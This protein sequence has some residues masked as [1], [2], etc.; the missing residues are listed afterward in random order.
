MSGGLI[1]TTLRV[2]GRARTSEMESRGK[3]PMSPGER[4]Q[5]WWCIF[6]TKEYWRR[7]AGGRLRE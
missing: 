4:I 1:S 5:S 3:R 7:T 2:S 6:S